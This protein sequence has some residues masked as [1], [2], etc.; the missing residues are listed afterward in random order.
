MPLEIGIGLAGGLHVAGPL[1]AVALRDPEPAWLQYRGATGSNRIKAVSKS[2]LA[3]AVQRRSVCLFEVVEL[4]PA[5][6]DQQGLA[7][8]ENLALAQ[9][10]NQ[11]AKRLDNQALCLTVEGKR[12]YDALRQ[13]QVTYVSR[14]SA[15]CVLNAA[16][17]TL[18]AYFFE[19]RCKEAASAWP[20]YGFEKNLGKRTPQHL[21]AL[22]HHGLTPIHR[23]GVSKLVTVHFALSHQLPLPDWLK[24]GT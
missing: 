8:S 1:V 14:Q 17:R 7:L 20:A 11:L 4:S 18:A 16:A 9:A 24:E 13:H 12:R 22:Y 10:V 21:K 23:A 6:V 19:L 3:A 5:N 15:Y 2:R